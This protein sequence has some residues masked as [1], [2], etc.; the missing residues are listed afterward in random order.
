MSTPEPIIPENKDWTWVLERACPDCGFDGATVDRREL[1]AAI[2]ENAASWPPV[3]DGAEATQRPQPTVWSPT[4]YACHVRD[5]HELFLHRLEQMLAEDGAEFANWDQD[6]AAV[7]AR[8]DQQAP[9]EVSAALVAAAERVAAVYDAVPDDAW[10]RRGLRSNGDAF[11]I[12]SFG[13]YHL[14]DVVHHLWDVGT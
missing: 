10:G 1:G 14:H 11:T 13:R 12:E 8:Y 7:A 6:A 5:V 3:L 2:R 4:E 9:G